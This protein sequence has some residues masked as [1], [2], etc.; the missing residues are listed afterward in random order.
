M[1]TLHA[2]VGAFLLGGNKFDGARNKFRNYLKFFEYNTQLMVKEVHKR[3]IIRVRSLTH[4]HKHRE[5]HKRG[6][7]KPKHTQ[8]STPFTHRIRVHTPDTDTHI[9]TQNKYLIARESSRKAYDYLKANNE[10]THKP[11]KRRQ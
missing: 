8:Y 10:H 9:H 7:H 4:T 1:F 2:M 11:R 3:Q 6:T 5:T